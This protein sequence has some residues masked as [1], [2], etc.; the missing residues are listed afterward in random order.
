ML[1][2][3]NFLTCFGLLAL[4]GCGFTPL[5]GGANG[6]AASAALETVQ[7]G[8]IPDRTGQVLR[9]TLQQDF[10][11]QGA[12][13][14]AL[15]ILSVSYN[16]AQ[17][18]EGV[19]ADSSTTRTRFMGEAQWQ[20]SPIGAPDKILKS[21]HAV[22]MDGLNVIDQ[23]YFATNLETASVQDRLAKEIAAQ[24]TA[25]LSVWFHEHPGS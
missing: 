12:P 4:S 14:Q 20:L 24:I 21:G 13:T 25:Q 16:V 3:R 19:Q 8:M 2:N 10:Y 6:K 9:Q 23:Q 7:V 17:T 1:L 18:G 11:V 22:A 15:Y 5:Y